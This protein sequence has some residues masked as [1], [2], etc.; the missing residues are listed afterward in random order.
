[1]TFDEDPNR[2]VG[3]SLAQALAEKRRHEAEKNRRQS[4]DEIRQ[5]AAE[6][7]EQQQRD[8]EGPRFRSLTWHG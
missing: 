4:P 5:K 6:V 3:V 2:P 7:L 1:M 8:A